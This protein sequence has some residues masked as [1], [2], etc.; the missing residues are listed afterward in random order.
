MRFSA[1]TTCFGY[2]S[3]CKHTYSQQKAAIKTVRISHESFKVPASARG[4]SGFSVCT[5]CWGKVL[6]LVCKRTGIT[7]AGRPIVR[8][9]AGTTC[10]G[11]CSCCKHTYSLRKAA[12]NKTVGVLHE[13]FKV[14]ASARGPS[15]FSLCTA[16][17]RYCCC[18]KHT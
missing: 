11:Y 3:C 9:S 8:F 7:T 14:P 12:I 1:G 17:W 5:T 10:F 4:P 18:F 16:C 2:C 6:L 15:G 13:S